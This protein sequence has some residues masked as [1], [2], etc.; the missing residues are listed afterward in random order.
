MTSTKFKNETINLEIL[1]RGYGQYLFKIT[2]NEGIFSLYSTDSMLIDA[3]KNDNEILSQYA[4]DLT[5]SKVL[6]SNDIRF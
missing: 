5:I 4:V 3:I 2:T 6:T 1:N